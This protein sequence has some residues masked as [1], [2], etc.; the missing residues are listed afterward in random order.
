MRLAFSFHNS[1]SSFAGVKKKKPTEMGNCP[2]PKIDRNYY[3]FGEIFSSYWKGN[4]NP[5]Y[6]IH[7]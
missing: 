4:F 3:A 5:F 2:P 7:I 1:F 6:Y